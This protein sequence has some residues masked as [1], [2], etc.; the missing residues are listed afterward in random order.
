M[1]KNRKTKQN[2]LPKWLPT[3]T[4]IALGILIFYPPF[5]RGLFFK[6]DMFLYHTFTAVVFTL[7]WVKKIYAKDYTL[8]KTPLDWAVFAYAGAYL[9]SILGAVHP[10][11][12]FYGFLRVLNL[13]MVYWMVSQLV[14]NYRDYATILK[15]LLAAGT[16]VAII[17]ILAATG[18]SDYPSA[19][20]GRVILS[21]LQYPNTT[22]AY[23]AV[24]SL[25]AISLVIIEKRLLTKLIYLTATFLMILVILCTLSKGA[26]LI[27]VIGALLLLIGMPGLHRLSSLYALGI[28][29]VAAG[30]TYTKFH[31][32]MIAEETALPYLLIGIAI[33]IIGQL[34]WEG[35]AL[36][37][38][39][40]NS[41]IIIITTS[42]I[43]LL[44]IGAGSAF[45]LG[46]SDFQAGD[47]SKE[48]SRF[49]DLS[50][51]S[52]TSRADFIRWGAAIVKDYPINGA[53]TD[54]WN[55]LYHQYQDY[56]FFTTEAHNHFIQVGVEAGLL[57]IIAFLAIWVCLILATYRTY[58]KERENSNLNG[59]ILIWGTFTA[60]VALGVHA[61]MDFDLSL[62]AM[63]LLLWILFALISAASHFELKTN[64][65]AEQRQTLR[66]FNLSVASLSILLLLICGTSYYTAY[67]HAVKAAKAFKVMQASESEAEQNAHYQVALKYY[68]K[69]VNLDANNAEYFTDLA[70]AYAI[71]Y[72]SL[73]QAE[74]P[75]ADIAY[76]ETVTAIERAEK[77][78]GRDVKVRSSLMNTASMLG[79][80]DILIRQAEGAVLANPNDI[81]AY[82]SLARILWAGI[83]HYQKAGE[84]A[85]QEIAYKLANLNE[86]IDKQKA[87]INPDKRWAGS[88]L[89]LSSEHFTNI[90]KSHY[91]QADYETSLAMFEPLISNLI[92]VEFADT[93]FENTNLENGDWSISSAK[94]ADAVNNSCLKVIAKKNITDWTQVLDL[95]SNIKIHE[96]AEY[97][98]E[99]RYK[100][101]R[102]TYGST[103][104][105]TNSLNI[106]SR[107]KGNAEPKNTDLGFHRGEVTSPTAWKIAQQKTTVD[108]GH[109]TRSIYIG[110][111]N[112]GK[113]S[114][115]YIDY[116]KLYPILNGNTPIELLDQYI[117]YA[118]SLYKTGNISS[119]TELAQE[120]K[121]INEESYNEYQAL[122]K[123]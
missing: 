55:A 17:G 77:L 26:W 91:I 9:L 53:G 85:P 111:R 73:R 82:E 62:V 104:D 102:L 65:K 68:E 118:A 71:R 47:I 113:D 95:A 69:A 86:Q 15:I 105:N 96:G 123:R 3:L 70:Y 35:F 52:Y 18:Y 89:E 25:L 39:K 14:K 33:V 32:A 22:A 114:T 112:I 29:F 4:L 117:W 59:Q 108:S 110:A 66:I 19:F 5:F 51:F 6:E 13:F 8:L 45:F 122:I 49:T 12:A 67:H 83:D 44:T 99:I 30:I 46:G 54:G 37:S 24:I 121:E 94:D 11:E 76:Q 16:G 27:F 42:L 63:A 107:N 79:D 41:K 97:L 98:L 93:E 90:A 23:L 60:S 101:D 78:K 31:P 106:I 115:F 48:L 36:L 88:P 7:I 50:D 58:N 109:D 120:I 103:K 81:N 84:K 43:A 72:T 75:L 21:T 61:A 56:L 92:K 116:V 34:L 40:I 20:N 2:T 80:L 1:A 28:A 87:K 119:A 10:G 38:Q 57:G 64:A 74:H 100:I